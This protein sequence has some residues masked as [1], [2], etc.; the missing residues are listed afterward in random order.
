MTN[1]RIFGADFLVLAHEAVG[2]VLRPIPVLGVDLCEIEDLAKIGGPF[3]ELGVGAVGH[4]TGEPRKAH[5]DLRRVDD[6]P[7]DRRVEDG[8]GRE[9]VEGHLV[10][11]LELVEVVVRDGGLGGF[12]VHDVLA[13]E[14]GN[15]AVEVAAEDV[16]LGSE[17]TFLL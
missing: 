15:D 7:A 16:G 12:A 17:G 4:S 5:R 9:G 1:G 14:E 11:G 6:Y 2:V 13:A 8:F 10:V 3:G